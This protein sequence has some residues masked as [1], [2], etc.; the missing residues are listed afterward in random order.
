[1]F[2][3]LSKLK[4][5]SPSKERLEGIIAVGKWR[6]IL[7]RGVCTCGTCLSRFQARLYRGF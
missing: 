7:T 6:Y 4:M 2:N 1:M 5:K 3:L